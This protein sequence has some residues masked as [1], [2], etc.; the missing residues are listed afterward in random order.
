MELKN[1]PIAKC[2]ES[3]T[4]PRGTKFEGPEFDELVASIKEKGVLMPILAREIKGKFEIVAGNRRLR[5]ASKAGLMEIPARIATMSDTEAREAQIVENLQRADIHPL[6]EGE[7][8]RQLIEKSGYDISAVGAKVGKTEGYI[9]DRLVLTNLTKKAKEQFRAGTFHAGHASL[10]G[11]L[12]EKQQ[13]DALE[14]L[15]QQT[16]WDG[17]KTHASTSDLRKWIQKR[18]L[19]DSIKNPPWTNDEDAKAVLGGCDECKGMGG[20]LFGKKAVDACTNPTCYA[21]R[22]AAYMDIQLKK[23]PS[24][25]KLSGYYS[26]TDGLPGQNARKE[27]TTKKGCA[28][29]EHGI[30][31]VGDGMGRVIR[32]CRSGDCKQ[33]WPEEKPRGGQYKPT[34]KEV[35]ERKKLA[36]AEKAKTEKNASAFRTALAKESVPLSKKHI[37][38]L[39][40]LSIDSHGSFSQQALVKLLGLEAVQAKSTYAK[41]GFVNDYEATLVK[42]ATD[43]DKKLQ[44]VFGLL[45]PSA[46]DQHSGEARFKKAIAQL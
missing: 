9:R 45:M 36:Q 14:Y 13:K 4:N 41:R 15:D 46:P 43:Q 29:E 31:V 2:Y 42:Y 12:D 16:T 18:A 3:P 21:N 19:A 39:F 30:V 38:S 27:I 33:H 11:R 5:A 8:Y 37:D 23:E 6:E 35:A 20:D 17:T 10:I 24:L 44:V 32:F 22:L 28:H 25:V 40:A 7:A 1:L 34:P 26:E